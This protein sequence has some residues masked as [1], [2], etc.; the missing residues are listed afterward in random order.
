MLHSIYD[1]PNLTGV[2]VQYVRMLDALSDNLPKVSAH[3]DDAR[4]VAR[5]HRIFRKRSGVR[6]CQTSPR[7]TRQGYRPSDRYRRCL[8]DR[9]S[10]I[11]LLGTV[12]GRAARRAD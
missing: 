2:E 1:Q 4:G 3:L 10:L 9:N 12:F 6:S 5:I 7:T 8:P 11:R